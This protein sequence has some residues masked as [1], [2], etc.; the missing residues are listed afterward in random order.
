MLAS[1]LA[2][3]GVGIGAILLIAFFF[4]I[5]ASILTCITYFVWNVLIPIAFHVHALT[6]G[7]CWILGIV[8]AIVIGIVRSN[9]SSS[10]S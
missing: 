5:S 6:W 4:G 3:L 8:F 1:I 7:Q 2:F 10:S 9:S